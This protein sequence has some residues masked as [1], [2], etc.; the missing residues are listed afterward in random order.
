[1]QM[2]SMNKEVVLGVAVVESTWLVGGGTRYLEE[3]TGGKMKMGWAV[4]YVCRGPSWCTIVPIVLLQQSSGGGP[5]RIH[6]LV[7]W[8]MGERVDSQEL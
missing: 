5:R 1:M 6:Q 4:F 8:E 3:G 2:K 7:G